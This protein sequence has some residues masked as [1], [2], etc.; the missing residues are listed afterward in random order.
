LSFHRSF[1]VA[2]EHTKQ[3]AFGN[4]RKW[5]FA[6][7]MSRVWPPRPARTAG[8]AP[9]RGIEIGGQERVSRKKT[10]NYLQLLA[11]TRGE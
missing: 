11:T 8:L 9:P 6:A 1:S 2:V 4:R 5:W 3:A 7:G 10:C